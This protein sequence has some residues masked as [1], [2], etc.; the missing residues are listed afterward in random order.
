M[1]DHFHYLDSSKSAKNVSKNKLN[2][3]NTYRRLVIDFQAV[4]TLFTHT[5]ILS[6][7]FE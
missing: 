6:Y 2:V 7:S 3:Q 5:R 1:E 4:K